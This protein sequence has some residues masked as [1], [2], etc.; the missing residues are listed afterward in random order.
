MPARASSIQVRHPVLGIAPV[1]LR[2]PSDCAARTELRAQA[3]RELTTGTAPTR[4]HRPVTTRLVR[5]R[6]R[7]K[8]I[9]GRGAKCAHVTDHG[10]GASGE[11]WPDGKCC[12]CQSFIGVHVNAHEAHLSAARAMRL[13]VDRAC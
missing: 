3:P 9:T 13:P 11:R 4:L 8:G 12:G 10:M 1:V 5:R 2:C 6:V 7:A